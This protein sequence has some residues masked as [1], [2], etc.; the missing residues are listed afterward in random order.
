M[1]NQKLKAITVIHNDA[2][3]KEYERELSYYFDNRPV[4]GSLE[5]DRYEL[6]MMVIGSY[7]DAH[8]SIPKS[9]AIDVIKFVMDQNGLKPKDLTPMIGGLNRVYEILNGT[10]TLTMP[11]ARKLH[12]QLKIPAECLLA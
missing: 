6:L 11:M 8:F 3:F 12:K 5:S 2:Q 7:D 1:I 4:K 10:R 9:S